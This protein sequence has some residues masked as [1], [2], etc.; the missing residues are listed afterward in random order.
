MYAHPPHA[1]RNSITAILVSRFLLELQEVN[2]TVIRAD[3]DDPLHLSGAS[4]DDKP[5]FVGSLGAVVDSEPLT[6]ADDESVLYADSRSE[7]SATVL[8]AS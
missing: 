5:S 6:S 2:H 7:V 1:V 4:Y 3:R 8:Y